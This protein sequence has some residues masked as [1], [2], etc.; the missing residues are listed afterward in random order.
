MFSSFL[1]ALFWNRLYPSEMCVR[2]SVCAWKIA[3]AQNYTRVYI[4]AVWHSTIENQ[5]RRTRVKEKIL[6]H[7]FG[8]KQ[9]KMLFLF[10]VHQF[11]N[12]VCRIV[13]NKIRFVERKEEG[14]K[15]SEKKRKSASNHSYMS[16]FCSAPDPSTTHSYTNGSSNVCKVLLRWCSRRARRIYMYWERK[17]HTSIFDFYSYSISLLWIDFSLSIAFELDFNSSRREGKNAPRTHT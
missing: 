11:L 14:R 5:L 12:D 4:V 13:R 17:K 16:G 10:L 1:V 8:C 2:V 9:W 7:V 15:K 3:A 6:F